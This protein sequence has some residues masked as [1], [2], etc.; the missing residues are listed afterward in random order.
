MPRIGVA[1]RD[2]KGFRVIELD[3]TAGLHHG[4]LVAVMR[5]DAEIPA[6]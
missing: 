5:G 3:N 4:D 2:K 1:R 6:S